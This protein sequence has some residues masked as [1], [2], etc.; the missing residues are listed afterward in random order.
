MDPRVKKTLLV[1][2]P[3][4]FGAETIN[5][6]RP[7]SVCNVLYK[8]I[9]KTIVIRLRQAMQTL[10]KQNQSSVIALRNISDNIIIVQE[11]IHYMKTTKSKKGWMVV[12][13]DLEKA[14]DRIWWDFLEDTLHDVGLP[15]TIVRTIMYYVSSSTLQLLWNGSLSEEFSPSR[16][17]HQG[18]PL[19]P[20]LFVLGME[21]LGHFIEN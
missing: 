4:F 10:V 14:Y 18:D 21:R 16:G 1:L 5:Q 12:K 19:S 8:I 7:I 2:I 17:V 3:K 11:I 9:T 13:V 15:A 20:Y 6:F